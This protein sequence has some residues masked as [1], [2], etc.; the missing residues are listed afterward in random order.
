MRQ[1]LLVQAFPRGGLSAVGC[2]GSFI[3]CWQRKLLAHAASEHAWTGVEAEGCAQVSGV[4]QRPRSY[5]EDCRPI[6]RF[7][8]RVEEYRLS[9]G[10][11]GGGG[12]RGRREDEAEGCTLSG[13]ILPLP[14]N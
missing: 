4:L 12:R 3:R 13:A 1:K 10:E 9:E 11:D 6:E 2:R 5:S 14:N 8:R 7:G